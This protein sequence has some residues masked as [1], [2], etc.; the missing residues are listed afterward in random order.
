MDR[1]LGD[2]LSRFSS[3]FI[4]STEQYMPAGLLP[5]N[6]D[7]QGRFQAGVKVACFSELSDQGG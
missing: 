6:E 2:P 5:M 4:A 1:T 7:P 3:P